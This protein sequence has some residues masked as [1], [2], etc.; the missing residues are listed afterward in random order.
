M[1]IIV[2]NDDG[3]NAAGL[4]ALVKVLRKYGELTVIA[5]KTAQ[6]GMSM[7]ITMG[8][9]PIAVKQLSDKPGES[10]WYLD[11]TPASCVKFAVDNILFPLKA[12]LVVSG[13]NHGSNA[14]TAAIY[15]GTVGAAMEGAVDDIPSIAVSLDSFDPDAD[16]S[17]VEQQ[18][19]AIL[20]KL[21]PRLNGRKG[22][23]YNINF[24]NIPASEVKGV[25][26]CRMGI[27]HWEKEYREWNEFLA[28]SGHKPSGR[29]LDYVAG[30]CEGERFYVMAGDF[31]SEACNGPHADHIALEEGYISITP[32]N[33]DNTDFKE[34]ERLCD[35]I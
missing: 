32:G 9:K 23:F 30:A 25:R 5:P 7:A 11:G 22:V 14:A 3:F 1:R 12:D 26:L 20:D 29:D 21:L 4:K 35:I 13:V 31:V 27:A 19:P 34:L 15:S 17:V 2:T 8:Y 18:L 10:W 28:E 33:I 16:F 24:P 6:S